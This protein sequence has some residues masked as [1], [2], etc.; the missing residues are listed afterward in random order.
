MV[1]RVVYKQTFKPSEIPMLPFSVGVLFKLPIFIYDSSLVS[2][3]YAIV[4]NINM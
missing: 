3:L 2:T 4:T 1:D